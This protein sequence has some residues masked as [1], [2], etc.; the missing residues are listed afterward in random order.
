MISVGIDVSKLTL[1]YCVIDG[2]TVKYD[3][4]KNSRI[5]VKKLL[6]GLE[7]AST[8]ISMEDTGCYN[9]NLYDVLGE[10]DFEVFV[11]NPFHLKRSLGLVRGKSDRQD[12]YR[13][14]MH[15]VRHYQDLERWVPASPEIRELKILLAERRRLLKE[16]VSITLAKQDLNPLKAS[17]FKTKTLKRHAKHLKSVN[18]LISELE[19]H[20]K[21]LINNNSHLS[22]LSK[23]IQSV[24]GVGPIVT[25][26]LLAK[27]NGFT[28]GRNPRQLAC[29]AGVV[30]FQQQSGTSLNSRPRLSKMADK[31][32][33][34]LLHLAAL[35]AVRSEASLKQYYERKVAE[36]KNK[37][38]VLNAIRNK[39]LHRICAVVRDEKYYEIK[40]CI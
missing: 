37:M 32:L 28:K 2:D 27:T 24:P 8:V 35:A 40:V 17:E 25:W 12:S 11:I 30:P 4:I 23:Y 38:S 5:A 34:T 1:D 19:T 18:K 7:L 26:Y 29:F 15:T 21:E 9:W 6:S 10:T 3:V 39:L 14:A 33:K 31:Q 36:G 22:T 13:I 16:K 20:I